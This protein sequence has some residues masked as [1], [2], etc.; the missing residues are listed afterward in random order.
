MIQ[1]DKRQDGL[2]GPIELCRNICQSVQNETAD[3]AD[4]TLATFSL[5]LIKERCAF[6]GNRHTIGCTKFMKTE[7]ILH[8]CPNTPDN[9]CQLTLSPQ[10]SYL[11]ERELKTFI[12]YY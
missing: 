10:L 2:G 7:T 9:E 12:T 11:L 6:L 3:R 4:G 5:F 8:D 1:T